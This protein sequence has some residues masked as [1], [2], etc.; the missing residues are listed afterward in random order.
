MT[1]IKFAAASPHPPIIILKVGQG[2]ERDTRRT[3]DALEGLAPEPAS[4]WRF[5]VKRLP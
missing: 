2:R 5:Q 1:A 3:I 4:L